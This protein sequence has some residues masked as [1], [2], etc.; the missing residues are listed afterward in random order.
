MILVICMAGLNTRFHDVGFDLPKYLLPWNESTVLDTILSELSASYR[1]SN[2]FLVANLRDK[3]F[4]DRLAEIAAA[5]RIPNEHIVFISDT[6]GQA[7]TAAVGAQIALEKLGK[8]REPVAFHNADTVITARDFETVEQKL[9][10]FDAYID[11]FPASSPSYAYVGIEAGLVT[12]IAE[13]KVISPFAS[14]GFYAFQSIDAYLASL[15]QSSLEASTELPENYITDVLRGMMNR[16]AKIFVNEFGQDARTIV[17][18][19][20]QEY[21]IELARQALS[22]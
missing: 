6:K 19:T 11:V 15:N 21:G 3:Y 22:R 4:G 12:K 13:K 2:I 14:S 9:K 20:P 17:L 1:F 18:G 8:L 7:H 10:T 5:H 16:G